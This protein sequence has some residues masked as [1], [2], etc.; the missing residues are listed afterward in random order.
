MSGEKRAPS[1]RE[2]IEWRA[3]RAW[4]RL[5]RPIYRLALPSHVA[6]PNYGFNRG[7]PI[8]RYYI[9]AFLA[10]HA[11]RIRGD[12]LE[13]EHDLY[14]RRF[15]DGRIRRSDILH[16]DPNF[17]AATITADL[18]DGRGVASN[19]FD[20]VIIT[21]T[22]H[23][24][25]DVTSA[26]RTL[27]RILKPNGSVLATVPAVA[28]LDRPPGHGWGEHWRFTSMGLERIFGDV[29]GRANVKVHVYGNLQVTIAGLMGLATEDLR[30]AELETRDPLYEY[31]IAA[32]ADK[33]PA[34]KTHAR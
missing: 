25:F 31:L 23:C 10:E 3:N 30:R 6:D 9:E 18:T 20:C 11:D 17:P 2:H 13:I 5:G 33:C 1:L 28:R 4:V 27:H 22:L 8:D 26:V 34:A 19:R 29:F 32:R 15:G 21:Q 12:V 7:R 14:T 24:I 16:V